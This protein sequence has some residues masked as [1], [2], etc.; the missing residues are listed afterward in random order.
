MV[1]CFLMISNGI[2]SML[3][4]A[5]LL[6]NKASEETYGDIIEHNFDWFCMAFAFEVATYN[7]CQWL[8]AFKSYYNT[9][10]IK[11]MFRDAEG[12]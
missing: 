1:I 2:F 10:E 12:D 5:L 4:V 6:K 9:R 11:L 8:Y 3:G 7:I